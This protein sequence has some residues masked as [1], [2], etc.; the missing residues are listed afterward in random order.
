MVTFKGHNAMK[1]YVKSKP[2]RWG[3]KLWMRA[4]SKTGY[5]YE[6]DIYTGK[7]DNPDVGLGESVVLQLT[8][9]MINTGTIVAFDNF[10]PLQ[11]YCKSYMKGRFALWEQFEQTGGKCQR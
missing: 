10:S 9:K 5:V 2:I 1:Q 8:E 7:K 3:F 11:Y 6:F 4:C